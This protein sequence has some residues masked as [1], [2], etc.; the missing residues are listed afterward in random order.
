MITLF[1]CPKPFR[2]HINIIQR[3]AIQSW[4]MLQP[5]PE[6]ILMGNEEGVEEVVEEFRLRHIRHIER[7]DHGTP[8]LGSLFYIAENAASHNL[9]CYIN[10]DIILLNDFIPGIQKTLRFKSH[11][12]MIGQRWNLDVKGP[13]DF[14]QNWQE[15]LRKEV[16][17]RGQLEI[18]NAIDYFIYH[19]GVFDNL[20]PFALGRTMWDN[21]LVSKARLQGTPV[22][23]LTLM[24]KVIHQN[25]TYSHHVRGKK[26][27]LKGKEARRNIELA[28]GYL[29]AFTTW[30]S[31]YELRND[32]VHCRSFLFRLYG[33]LVDLSKKHPFLKPVARV[34]RLGREGIR[35]SVYFLRNAFRFHFN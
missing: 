19:K 10:T 1:A 31:D 35:F 29:F 28:K 6:I 7:N 32:G 26:G 13:I 12:L 3:N 15:R 27:V 22:V 24:V 5:G 8:L 33:N 2:Q 25:H 30:D 21:W 23:D 34:V 9:M 18:P 14:S 11:C 4:R 16:K 20:L 17:E